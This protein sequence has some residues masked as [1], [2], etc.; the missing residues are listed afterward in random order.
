MDRRMLMDDTSFGKQKKKMHDL[1]ERLN[2]LGLSYSNEDIR[3]LSKVSLFEQKEL[4]EK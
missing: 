4:L 2:K 3:E 1:T